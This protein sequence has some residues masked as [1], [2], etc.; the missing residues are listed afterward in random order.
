LNVADAEAKYVF[1]F[2]LRTGDSSAMYLL[3]GTYVLGE[4]GQYID[5]TYSKFNGNS[6]AFSD[7]TLVLV[8]H[9]DSDTYDVEFDVTLS[10]GT[11]FKGTYSG[12]IAGTPVA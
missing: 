4:E 1:D 6:K 11:N 5:F 12:P 2:D 8:Y 9:A 10:D 7:A 3:P